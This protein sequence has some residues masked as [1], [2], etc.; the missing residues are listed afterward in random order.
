[1]AHLN[2]LRTTDFILPKT[3]I[4][5]FPQNDTCQ[6]PENSTTQSPETETLQWFPRI[7]EK[8]IMQKTAPHT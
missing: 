7:P 4:L 5:Q 1:M 2:L 8:N 3:E 6:S